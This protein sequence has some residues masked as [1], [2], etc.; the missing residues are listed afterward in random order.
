MRGQTSAEMLILVGGILM[1]VTSMVYLGM[2]G[3]E[4]AVVMQ[5]ARD[6]AENVIAAFDAEY[7]CSADINGVGFNAGVI[8]IYVSIRDSPPVVNF[9]NILKENIRVGALKYIQN[10]VGGS[11]PTTAGPVKT[12]YAT[13]DVAV[14]LRRVTK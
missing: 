6:G 4:S 7:G 1:V 14:D 11:F 12:S 5:A 10:S 2:G 9:D 8:T 13:Y 3:N